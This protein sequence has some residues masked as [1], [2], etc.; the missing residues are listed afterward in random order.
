LTAQ[1]IQS[2]EAVAI[3]DTS[4]CDARGLKMAIHY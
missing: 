2:G 4:P 1:R 3:P